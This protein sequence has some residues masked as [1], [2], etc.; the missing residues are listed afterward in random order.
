MKGGTGSLG[1]KEVEM[2]KYLLGIYSDEKSIER[3]FLRRRV[4]QIESG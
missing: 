2:A 1:Q 3:G 4:A